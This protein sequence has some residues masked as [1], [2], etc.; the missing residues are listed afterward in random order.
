MNRLSCALD[1]NFVTKKGAKMLLFALSS[2]DGLISLD[3]RLND[4]QCEIV[5]IIVVIVFALMNHFHCESEWM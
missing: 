2:N 1:R 3:L 5:V 4:F